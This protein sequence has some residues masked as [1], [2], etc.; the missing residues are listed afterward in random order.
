MLV[1]K[2]QY[3]H[4]YP[5]CWRCKSPLLMLSVEQWF[6]Q[7]RGIQEKMLALNKE[8]NWVPAWMKGRMHN[9]LEGISDWPISRARYWGTP[10]PIWTCDKCGNKAVVGTRKELKGLSK[11]KEI[12][13]HKPGIDK[14]GWNC[15]CGGKMKRVPEILD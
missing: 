11:A 5:V 15:A 7:I 10:L 8:V 6:L 3:T 4:D 12:D 1:Y 13:M 2:H 14:I 9:W